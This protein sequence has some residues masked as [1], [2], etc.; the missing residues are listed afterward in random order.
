LN[1]QQVISTAYDAGI[2]LTVEAGQLKIKG[3]RGDDFDRIVGLL[4]PVKADVIEALMP[5]PVVDAWVQLEVEL[6]L[7]A[8]TT[9]LTDFV[10]AIV[11]RPELDIL[12]ARVTAKGWTLHTLPAGDNFYVTGLAAQRS[13]GNILVGGEA[14]EGN[15]FYAIK[16][17]SPLYQRFATGKEYKQWLWPRISDESGDADVIA[18]LY[19]IVNG[20]WVGCDVFVDGPHADIVCA[21]ANYLLSQYSSEGVPILTKGK[22]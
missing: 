13:M 4:R 1:A 12:Q 8:K 21:A 15:C 2:T 16:P 17:G 22:A 20:A 19:E 18:A 3:T 7:D 5:A 6:T 14:G 11:T 9:D 10:G